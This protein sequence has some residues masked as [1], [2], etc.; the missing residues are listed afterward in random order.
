[1]RKL[2][3]AML[4]AAVVASVGGAARA[5]DA[6]KKRLNAKCHITADK[7]DRV[8]QGKTLTIAKGETVQSAVAI[9]GDVVVRAGATVKSAVAI[10]GHVILEPGAVVTKDA[11]AIGGDLKL[12]DGSKVGKDAV[13]IGGR[14]TAAESSQIGGDQ[15]SLSMGGSI[16]KAIIDEAIAKNGQCE[17]SEK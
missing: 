17:I 5:E 1:M 12:A 2:G 7:G 15:V 4:A 14:L 11:V 6:P 3:V 13:V 16:V 10:N 9:D 8:V